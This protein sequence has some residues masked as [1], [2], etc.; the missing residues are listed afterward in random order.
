MNI[1]RVACV[2]AGLIGQGWATV[3]STRCKK[4]MVQDI[5][6]S[7]LEE[8][9]RRIR[10]NLDFLES[11]DLIPPGESRL[12]FERITATTRMEDA[13]SGAGYVQESVPDDYETKKRVFREMDAH[14]PGAAILGSSSSG[15]LMT[16]IQKAVVRPARCVLVHPFL[17]VHLLP[18]VEIAGGR[19]TS[20]DTIETVCGFISA[21]GKTPVRLK[22]EVP[23]YIVNRLQAALVREAID[24]VHTGV[25]SA[26]DVDTA[27]RTA[28]GLRDPILGPFLRIHLAAN[29]AER[30]FERYAESYFS[31]WSTMATW[32]AVPPEAAR[33]A[34]HGINEMEIVRS[35]TPK[36]LAR[37]RDEM[38]VRILKAV[39][40]TSAHP[41]CKEEPATNV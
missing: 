15:L 6:E 8:A 32:T 31:R 20:H 40:L 41:E 2:G 7:G 34:V 27:F 10:A 13:I 29:G 3:F 28:I 17:P 4:V 16:E 38:L 22:R 37:W 23:G 30:F 11:H 39:N 18:C 35:K 14:A 1:S 36:E 21:L 26:E 33:A 9:I 12:A 19:E 25:A 24:L 5:S